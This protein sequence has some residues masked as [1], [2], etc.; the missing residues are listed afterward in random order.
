MSERYSDIEIGEEEDSERERKREVARNE[1]DL[2]Q[3][4]LAG[5]IRRQ[6]KKKLSK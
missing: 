2:K 6:R 5:F 4:K 3:R 1:K